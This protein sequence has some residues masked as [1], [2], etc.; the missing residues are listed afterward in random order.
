MAKK[1]DIFDI[2]VEIS[3]VSAIVSGLSNQFED[4]GTRLNADFMNLAHLGVSMHL[5]RIS[6]DIEAM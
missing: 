3:A 5:D 2:S 4:D 6:E 1:N